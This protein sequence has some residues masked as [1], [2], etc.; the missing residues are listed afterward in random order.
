VVPYTR[1]RERS[2]DPE[3]ITGE[4]AAL[5][6]KGYREVTLLGQNVNSYR[7]RH[8]G[9]EI[10]FP[11]LLSAVA[12]AVPGMR[13]R[14]ATSHPR[15]LSDELIR[16]IATTENICNHVHLPAQSGSD[17]ILDLMN[18][19]YSRAW[20]TGRVEALRAAI[21]DV[22]ISTDL[23]AGFSS[24]TEDDHRLT[25]SLMEECRFDFAF[26]FAYSERPGTAAAGT[27]ADDVPA[28]VKKSRLSEII[29]LQ[30]RLSLSGNKGDVGKRFPVLVEGVSKKSA[31]ALYGRT[32]QN[33]VVVF[34]AAGLR[35]GDI[36]VVEIRDCTSATLLGEVVQP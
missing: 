14:F 23:I 4:C 22:A 28:A 13:I 32:P 2:R 10:R 17:R 11:V 27:L 3:S 7:W 35:A 8:D 36:A 18:R 1:G 30:Q 15:D 19:K 5:Y 9:E 6:T 25:L 16:V 29:T 12:A 31:E 33:K 21:P 26:M 20:Y 24:E 34:P